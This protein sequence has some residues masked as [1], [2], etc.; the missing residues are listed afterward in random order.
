MAIDRGNGCLDDDTCNRNS[1]CSSTSRHIDSNICIE[2]HSSQNS[3]NFKGSTIDCPSKQPILDPK[4]GPKKTSYGSNSGNEFDRDSSDEQ[5]T[6][7]SIIGSFGWFQLAVLIFSGLREGAVGYDALV[8]SIVLQPETGYVCDTSMP[9]L[10]DEKS[11]YLVVSDS[12]QKVSFISKNFN[13]TGECYKYDNGDKVACDSWQFPKSDPNRASLVVEWSLVCNRSWIV[14]L[15]ES[16]FF[17]GLVVGNLVW[18]LLADKLGRKKCYILSHTL[19]L[20]AGWLALIMP[21]VELFTVCRFLAALGSIG[22]NIIYTIQMELIGTKYRSCGTMFNHLGWGLGAI[23]I[24]L[25]ASLTNNVYI[26][27]AISPILTL[28]M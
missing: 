18:G 25:V 2:F 12:L 21:N 16:A 19:S 27:L 6:V 8:T 3:C 11:Q 23:S 17:F 15:I 9:E 24:P 10:A 28:I 1:S 7:S 20:I 14:A 26:L 13:E 22:Y 4:F 5:I